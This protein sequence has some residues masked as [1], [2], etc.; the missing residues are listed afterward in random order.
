M[1][2]GT[3]QSSSMGKSSSMEEV[4][5]KAVNRYVNVNI[6]GLNLTCWSNE[7]L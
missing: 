4:E 5:L 2:Y 3:P 6:Q 7:L 1:E